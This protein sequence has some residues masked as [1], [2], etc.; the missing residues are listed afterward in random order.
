[1][2]HPGGTGPTGEPPAA[3]DRGSSVDAA[4]TDGLVSRALAGLRTHVRTWPRRYVEMRVDARSG[5]RD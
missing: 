2:S 3:P 5:P 4:P 1:M